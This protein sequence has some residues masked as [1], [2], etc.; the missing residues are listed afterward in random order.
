MKILVQTSTTHESV[1]LQH[2]HQKIHEQTQTKLN[3]RT[4]IEILKAYPNNFTLIEDGNGLFVKPITNLGLCPIH[5]SKRGTC[6]GGNCEGLHI[7]KFYLLSDTC[8]FN[9]R[10]C[11]FGHD[12]STS[13]NR[14]KIQQHLLDELS[15]MEQKILFRKCVHHTA[16]TLPKIC[17][18][19][20]VKEGRCRYSETG[21][22]C[23]ALHICKHYILGNCSYG[24]RCKRNHNLFEFGVDD[25]LKKHGMDVKRSAK[26]ILTDLR[27]AFI[28]DGDEVDSQEAQGTRGF[29]KTGQAKK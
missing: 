10:E 25:V 18:F 2:L 19:Y 20:N 6:R 3:Q 4:L 27:N 15:V 22:V 21:S 13:H 17:K 7:C 26:E 8:R 23:P 29:V 9:G 11:S 16:T 28:E 24:P 14:Q 5:C 12:L 1:K